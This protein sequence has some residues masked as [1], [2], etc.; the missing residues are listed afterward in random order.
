M[1]NHIQVTHRHDSL[2]ALIAEL[3]KGEM[4]Q[5]EIA[6]VLKCSR[7][8]V[9]N[10]IKGLG[11]LV[12]TISHG[13]VVPN[14]YRITDDRQAIDAFLATL[15]VIRKGSIRV[16]DRRTPT[17]PTR[18]IH[19]MDDDAPFRVPVCHVRPQHPAMHLAF[20]GVAA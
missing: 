18:H 15:V 2:R 20:W 19:I 16:R 8:G 9:R 13:L 11:D 10:Y 12:E 14:T 17:D 7:S 3:Q 1:N 6:L 4:T 5:G